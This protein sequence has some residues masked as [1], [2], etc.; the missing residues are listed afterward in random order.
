[1]TLPRNG[2]VA[3]V[4]VSFLSG[5][6][7]AEN[8]G[9]PRLDEAVRLKLSA[10]RF[11]ELENVVELCERALEQG[12]SE[13]HTKVAKQLMSATLYERAFHVVAPILKGRIDRSWPARR[14][15]ALDDLERAVNNNPQDGEAHLLIA[16][17]HE[18]M[19]R[20][21]DD[22]PLWVTE[23]C[24]PTA[25]DSQCWSIVQVPTMFVWQFG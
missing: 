16:R 8:E 7:C 2:F 20:H 17:L 3:A 15:Q 14:K 1:M 9:L 10:E 21:G 23:T 4:I 5:T 18:V 22:K 6:L 11:D 13:G 19:A 24:C 25:L 12:L